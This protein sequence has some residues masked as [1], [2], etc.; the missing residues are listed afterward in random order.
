[1]NPQIFTFW[2]LSTD[3]VLQQTHSTTAGLSRQ[4]A[5]QRLSQYGANSLKQTHKS[6]ALMLLIKG[7]PNKKIVQNQAVL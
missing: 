6:S 1:M 2:N 5:K 3:R 7:L 4:D